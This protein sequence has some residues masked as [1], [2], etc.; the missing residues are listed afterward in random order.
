MLA[1]PRRNRDE[2][3]SSRVRPSF[4]ANVLST[5]LERKEDWVVRQGIA[6]LG[7]GVGDAFVGHLVLLEQSRLSRSF[8]QEGNI[9]IERTDGVARAL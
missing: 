6:D 1:L 8:D 9:L 4:A 7:S 2:N 3:I 5:M